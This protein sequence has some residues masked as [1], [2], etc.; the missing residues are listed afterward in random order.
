MLGLRYQGAL[1]IGF[2][3]KCQAVNNLTNNLTNNLLEGAQLLEQKS[4]T[5]TVI[6]TFWIYPLYGSSHLDVRCVS[7]A[8]CPAGT[9]LI[10]HVSAH[11][12]QA[13]SAVSKVTSLSIKLGGF[14]P[15][16][17]NL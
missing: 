4:L 12:F 5:Y 17:N 2:S 9:W 8:F 15:I 11:M 3:H 13:W 14:L 6:P 1:N 16:Q 7:T 10:R